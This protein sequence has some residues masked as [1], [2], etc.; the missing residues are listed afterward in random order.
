MQAIAKIW[1][2]RASE[3]SSKFCEQLKN[4]NGPF[5]T[6]VSHKRD[7]KSISFWEPKRVKNLMF[8]MLKEY[9]PLYIH[10]L[11]DYDLV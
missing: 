11:C 6:P 5:I 1:G 10:S 8:I 4:F 3:H 7:S 2:A 9:I